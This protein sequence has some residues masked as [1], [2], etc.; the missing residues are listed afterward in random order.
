MP[1]PFENSRRKVARAKDL[2]CDLERQLQPFFAPDNYSMV[3][4]PHPDRAE[5]VVQKIKFKSTFPVSASSI[6]NDAVHNL[7]SALDNACH[8]LAVLGGVV[9]PRHCAFPFAGGALDLEN[10]IA[11]RCKDIRT[12]FCVVFRT[13]KPYVGGNDALWALNYLDV[14]DKHTS[15]TVSVLSELGKLKATGGL[16][17]IP[18]EPVWDPVQNEIELATLRR[19][20]R[21][22][23]NI[24]LLFD[25]TYENV[26]IID[27]APVR[28]LLR[29][30]VE[31]V[32][33]ILKALD[34]EARRLGMLVQG[35]DYAN[36]EFDH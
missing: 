13:Y 4:E 28:E 6:A 26:A 9:T 3:L 29:Y 30:F 36:T 19:G 5:Y 27:G 23:M 34:E 33:H 22:K 32:E 10:S 14:S 17:S 25:A 31:I 24:E 18:M 21:V 8:D 16:V 15:L 1:M 7:R 12:E 35:P 11:G 2:I 20:H